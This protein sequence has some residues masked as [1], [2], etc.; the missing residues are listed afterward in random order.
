MEKEMNPS[1]MEQKTLVGASAG[2]KNAEGKWQNH[3]VRDTDVIYEEL[4]R[5]AMIL[6][7]LQLNSLQILTLDRPFWGIRNA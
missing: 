6:L 2:V 4:E 7:C 1:N 5:T 3:G